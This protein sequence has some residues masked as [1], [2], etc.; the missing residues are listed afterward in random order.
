MFLGQSYNKHTSKLYLPNVV[1][2]L[3]FSLRDS[4]RLDNEEIFRKLVLF[5]RSKVYKSKR[6]G[7]LSAFKELIIISVKVYPY[8]NQKYRANLIDLIA[9]NFREN[10]TTSITIIKSIDNSDDID[11]QREFCEISYWATVQL[12]KKTIE[13]KDNGNFASL[14]NEL[15]QITSWFDLRES[16]TGL[17]EN[18]TEEIRFMHRSLY[19][20]TYSWLIFCYANNKISLSEIESF[21]LNDNILNE[22]HFRDDIELFELFIKLK[23]RS[24]HSFLEIDDWELEEHKPGKAY[25]ALSSRDWL[26]FGFTILLLNS[27][28]L[29]FSRFGREIEPNESLSYLINDIKPILESIEKRLTPFWSEILY[30]GVAEDKVIEEFNISKENILDFLQEIKKKQELQQYKNI[31]EQPI[32]AEKVEEFQ[33]NVLKNWNNN[34]I[35][36]E[37]LKQYNS[38][39]YLPNK[40]EIKGFGYFNLYNKMKSM[41]TDKGNNFVYGVSD[42]GARL[43]RDI[44]RQFYSTLK[45]HKDFIEVK[46]LKNKVDEFISKIED[47]SKYVILTDWRGLDLLNKDREVEYLQESTNKFTYA[48][49]KDISVVNKSLVFPNTLLII[50]IENSV[51]YIIYQDDNWFDKELLI[52]VKELTQDVIDSELEKYEEKWK[53]N[54]EYEVTIEEAE[55]LIKSSILIKVLFKSEMKVKN[56]DYYAF[57]KF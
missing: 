57:F 47:S 23:S 31:I 5:I 43:A 2:A 15:N 25:M 51:D 41:F 44:E 3:L 54:D 36:P 38:V 39:E 52:D 40:E 27:R 35:I 18:I 50:D 6:D 11:K 30:N 20:I 13:F 55:L 46:D 22:F 21:N 33:K 19:L 14:F 24:F 1:S 9:I 37:L 10:I 17:Q 49:Y 26:N 48:K 4:S 56:S 34:N 12:L 45:F 7:S 16:K 42:V 8:L 32:S 29:V 28:K 53:I